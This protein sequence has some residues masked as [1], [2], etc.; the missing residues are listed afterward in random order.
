MDMSIFSASFIITASLLL[1][2][3]VFCFFAL[4]GKK[5]KKETAASHSEEEYIPEIISGFSGLLSTPLAL[6]DGHC[7]MLS[8]EDRHKED[9]A[10]IRR[11]SQNIALAKTLVSSIQKLCG[12]SP[13]T[14]ITDASSIA[15][16]MLESCRKTAGVNPE[17]IEA[18]IQ[19]GLIWML[20]RNT[21][22][23]AFHILV[24][25]LAE[26]TGKDDRIHIRL[27]EQDGTLVL[28][29]TADG[30]SGQDSTGWKSLKK[31]IDRNN[32]TV[33][34]RSAAEG[35]FGCEIRFAGT[36]S[37]TAQEVRQEQET[38][39]QV[40]AAT[41]EKAPVK[42]FDNKKKT[43]LI[44]NGGNEMLNLISDSLSET[45]NIMKTSCPE[46]SE[47]NVEMAMPDLV[48]CGTDGN[49][50]K[51]LLNHIKDRKIT[52]HIPVVMVETGQE[53]HL[54]EN[55]LDKADCCISM[56]VDLKKLKIILKQLLNRIEALKDYYT[57]PI[58]NY[59][60][61][62]GKVLHIEDKRFLDR[63]HELI[64][65]NV[66]DTNLSPEF[67]A[68]S[69]SMSLRNL[70]R[71]FGS[72]SSDKLASIIKDYRLNYAA[73][74]LATSKYTVDEIIFKAG[75][76]N[77]GTFFKLFRQKYDMTP[78]Q[79]MMLRQSPSCEDAAREMTDCA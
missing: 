52:M 59:S 60:I 20:D 12:N 46:D 39:V 1:I 27:S 38:E 25:T 45:Y 65:E 72:I 50:G 62:N 40:S 35:S 10:D 78:K 77:R 61:A 4:A 63:I 48:I 8:E 44:Q 36:A 73:S 21:L 41:L 58:S 26:N 68:E 28:S 71:K 53:S 54:D 22:E 49:D 69:M 17:R 19:P 75:F 3:T 24:R 79:Y 33:T 29:G 56:P 14:E 34:F 37:G 31:I 2:E 64:A 18:D 42:P 76:V 32:G 6:I 70:Y 47:K 16:V 51:Q 67:I 30:Y 66:S 13:C 55:S 9:N 15:S 23:I 7:Q 5:N 57:S 11:I 43:I 74:L